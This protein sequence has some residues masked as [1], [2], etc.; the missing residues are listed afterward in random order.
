MLKK[1]VIFILILSTSIPASV[2]Q[3]QQDL[4]KKINA[5]LSSADTKEL[6]K[7]FAS[8]VNLTLPGKEGLFSK[9]QTETLLR[10][11]FEANKP[12]T[13]TVDRQGQ[14]KEKSSYC[15]ARFSSSS[16][17]FSIYYLVREMDNQM[18]I[19]Q[20]QIEETQN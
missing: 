13:F 15:V 7:Y 1:I 8:F 3:S 18:Q 9:T 20:L 5:S 17:K 2:A 6:S 16:K 10:Q 14:S 12:L 11:F 19:V 4:N